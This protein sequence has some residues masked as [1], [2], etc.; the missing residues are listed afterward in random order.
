M[1]L[2]HNVN[3]PKSTSLLVFICLPIWASSQELMFGVAGERL[4]C[5]PNC[6]YSQELMFGVAG[7]RLTTRMRK[8]MFSALLRQE[9]TYFDDVKHTV[10]VLCAR[11]SGDASALQG[12]SL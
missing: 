12:V 10:G 6:A 2:L 7:E 4:I 5:L 1:K 8:L 11:L 3:L 9:V